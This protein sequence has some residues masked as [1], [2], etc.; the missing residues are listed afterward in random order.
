MLSV[1]TYDNAG[2]FLVGSLGSRLSTLCIHG[3]MFSVI[4][5]CGVGD[6]R[7]P[8]FANTARRVRWKL[9]HLQDC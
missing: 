8:L 7:H 2:L 5:S 9:S 6:A 1:P 3:D 4:R